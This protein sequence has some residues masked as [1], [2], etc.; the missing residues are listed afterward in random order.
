M[1]KHSDKAGVA[2]EEGRSITEDG[3]LHSS[4]PTESVTAS[5]SEKQDS[6]G[7]VEARQLLKRTPNSY[8]YYQSYC[9]WFFISWFFLTVIITHEVSAA[10]YGIFAISLTAYNTILY[11]VALGLEDALTTYVPRIFAEQGQAAAAALTRRLLLARF[12][13]LLISVSIM[14]SALPIIGA[15]I[16]HLPI[17]GAADAAASLNNPE[18]L[19]H[20]TPIAIYVFG[21]SIGSLLNA[22]CAALMRMRIVFFIGSV[23]QCVLLGLGFGVLHLGW[24][25]N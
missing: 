16:A 8:L 13:V 20:I 18:L 22:V 4:T 14:L 6:R 1:M 17:K 3:M 7:E 15:L 23:T 24:G 19:S 9:L 2:G 5:P 21:S 25:I 12:V 10:Q 11:I